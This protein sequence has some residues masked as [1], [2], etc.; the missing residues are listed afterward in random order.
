VQNAS[1]P[2]SERKHPEIFCLSLGMRISR[3]AWLCRLPDYAAS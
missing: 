3:S 1:M 2:D